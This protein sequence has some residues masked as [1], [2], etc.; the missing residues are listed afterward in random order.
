MLKEILDNSK[1]LWETEIIEE[2]DDKQYKLI[3]KNTKDFGGK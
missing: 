2:L 1:E 3:I